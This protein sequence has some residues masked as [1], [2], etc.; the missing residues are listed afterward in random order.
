MRASGLGGT[1][2]LISSVLD[3]PVS[4]TPLAQVWL[5]VI[6]SFAEEIRTVH[7]A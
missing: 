2:R 1:A 7:P 3:E 5:Q 4:P 6:G